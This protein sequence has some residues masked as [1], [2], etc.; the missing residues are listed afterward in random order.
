MLIAS[1]LV[2]ASF[3]ATFGFDYFL[4]HAEKIN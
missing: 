1:F 4:K 2:I 3:L